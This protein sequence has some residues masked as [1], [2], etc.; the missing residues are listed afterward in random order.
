MKRVMP[1]YSWTRKAIPL[2]IEATI[3]AGP[4]VMAYPRLMEALALANGV[5]P[6]QGTT[7]LF[8]TDQMFPDWV[9]DRGIGPILGGAGN[10]T[11]VNP[12]TPILDTLTLLGHP[13]QS[14]IDMMNPMM[15]VPIEVN[16]GATLGRQVPIGDTNSAW[17]DYAAKQIPIVSQAGRA[18]GQFGV[19]ESTRA[20]GFPNYTNILNL[21]TGAKA[22]NTGKYQKSAQFDL[23][24]YLK[25]KGNQQGR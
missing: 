3:F 14:S 25:Q 22:V 17:M 11:V 23:R 7:D 10:Y 4:K 20:E 9:R 18:S 13:G 6:A 8:P 24:D 5:D 19:S 16:Q 15:K 21:L 2:A 1:F 12:S